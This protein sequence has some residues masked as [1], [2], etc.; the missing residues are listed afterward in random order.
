MRRTTSYRL[1]LG[2]LLVIISTGPGCSPALRKGGGTAIDPRPEIILGIFGGMGPEATANL[3]QLIVERTPA[4]RDQEHIPTLIYSLPTVPD[5]TASIFSGDPS[6]LPYLAEGVTRLEKSGASYIAIPCNTA[7]YF[8]DHMQQ[9]VKI[10]IINMIREAAAEVAT[11]Y[12]QAKKVGLLATTGTIST[13]LYEKEFAARGIEMIKPSDNILENY[14]M[15]AVYLIK[16]HGDKRQCEEWLYLAG[17]EL[18]KSGAEVVVLGCTEIPLAFNSARSGVP[19]VSASQVL[20]DRAI[21]RFQLLSK[22]PAK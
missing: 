18:E 4:T 10:P 15:K 11:K 19:V 6:I 14:V 8:Y 20:A 1:I 22:Q 7:H 5:R 12:P 16:A 3:Y 9:A 17:K 2:I 21:A 13:G